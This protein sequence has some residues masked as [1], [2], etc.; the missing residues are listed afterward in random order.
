MS[1]K[2]KEN[3]LRRKA[4]RLNLMLHKSRARYWNYDNQQGWMITDPYN[5]DAVIQ[6][7]KYNLTI[8]E[9]EEFLDE[10]EAKLRSS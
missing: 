9:V 3:F 5:G 4:E 8:E 2:A 7:T 6:G 1:N 10:Y